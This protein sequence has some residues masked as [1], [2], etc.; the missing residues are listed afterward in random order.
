[1]KQPILKSILIVAALACCGNALCQTLNGPQPPAAAPRVGSANEVTLNDQPAPAGHRKI[2]FFAEMSAGVASAS[3]GGLLPVMGAGGAGFVTMFTGQNS[4][5]FIGDSGIFQDKFGE[6]GIGTTSPSSLLTVAGIVQSTAGGFGFPDGTLQSTAGLSAVFHNATLTGSGSGG[7][8]LSIANGGVGSLQLAD[9]TAIRGISI[10]GASATD[11]VRL[12]PG[13]NI[14]ISGVI[15]STPGGVSTFTIAVPNALTQVA[16]DS[17]LTGNGTA[18][19]PLAVVGAGT[20]IAYNSDVSTAPGTCFALDGAGMDI[21][22]KVIPPGSYVIFSTT[23]VANLDKGGPQ[24]A[25]CT[26]SSPDNPSF[27]ANG[28]AIRLPQNGTGMSF[29]TGCGDIRQGQGNI[30]QQTVAA[31]TMPTT[32]TLHCNG[33]NIESPG[34]IITAIKVASIQ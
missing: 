32:L 13:A 26:I 5:W 34:G 14:D 9:G 23:A 27:V 21:T 8:P 29:V 10:G 11:F 3:S 12:I 25:T 4:N 16:H 7:S 19:S 31:V 17:S 6:I 28:A 1:M 18:A 30:N 24:T 20:N 22:S 2:P 15:D 33:S